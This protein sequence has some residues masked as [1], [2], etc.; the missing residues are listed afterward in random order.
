[1]QGFRL[2]GSKHVVL[3]DHLSGRGV[4][5]GGFTMSPLTAHD[6]SN[7]PV[8]LLV[9][10]IQV[11]RTLATLRTKY[12]NLCIFFL[13]YTFWESATGAITTI[14]GEYVIEQLR[15]PVAVPVS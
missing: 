11:G 8:V 9:L 14:T 1:M 6:A 15:N 10:V 4:H 13:G 3:V 7:L 12:P 5:F 2:F